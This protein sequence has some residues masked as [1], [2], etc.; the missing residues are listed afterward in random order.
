MAK[1][2]WHE[3]DPIGKVYIT[4]GIIPVRVIGVVAD[5][6]VRGIR[7][8]ILPQAYYPHTGA[9]N[10]AGIRWQLVVK[11]GV[12]PPSVLGTVRKELNAMDSSLAI[13]R[14]RTM[15]DVISDTMQDTSIQAFLLSTFA[16]LALLLAAVG[17]YSVMAYLVVQRTHEVGIRVALGAR[18]GDVLRLVL[19]HGSRLTLAGMAAGIAVALALNQLIRSLL[20]GIS[21]NDLPTFAGVVILLAAVALI[22]C[23][24]PAWRATRV[25]PLVALRKE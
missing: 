4:G 13:F 21:A 19:G 24:V 25:D 7:S 23:L 14:P 3:E 22:A 1:V 2:I 6:K 5:V 16:A 15:E 10:N 9:L 20:Y 18:R 12:S 8:N 11:T 17:L